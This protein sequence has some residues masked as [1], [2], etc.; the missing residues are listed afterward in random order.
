MTAESVCSRER[1]VRDDKDMTPAALF[2]GRSADFRAFADA[3]TLTTRDH[4]V[5]DVDGSRLEWL[6]DRVAT[7][8]A[9]WRWIVLEALPTGIRI[10][11]ALS[12]VG[13]FLQHGHI[14]QLWDVGEVLY[15]V[16]AGQALEGVARAHR[17]MSGRAGGRPRKAIDM[18]VAVR[19]V[20]QMGVTRAAGHLGVSAT[21]LR[22][23]LREH[24]G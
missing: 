14:V 10:T 15:G 16:Q 22:S 8:A 19:L 3:H 17:S 23:R 12:L 9:Q 13:L 2:Y 20:E 4:V 5:I 21:T 7:S 18:T 6:R 24:A 1:V 11:D